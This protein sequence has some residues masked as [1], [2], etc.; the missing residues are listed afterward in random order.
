VI[1]KT[2]TSKDA[3]G[4]T[5]EYE[6]PDFGTYHHTTPEDSEEIRKQAK[7]LFSEAF[8]D[9]P[10]P[11]DDKLKILDIGCGLGFL[12]CVCAEYYPNGMV[13]AFDTFEDPSLENSSLEKAKKN[14]D[15]LG[16]SG[17]IEFQKGDI[18]QSNYSVD[19]F[20]LFVSNLVFHN[21]GERRLDAYD[22]LASW[23]RPESYVVLGELF[24]DY[25][26]D[27]KRLTSL[28][29]KVEERPNSSTMA[30][31]YKI[32]VLSGPKKTVGRTS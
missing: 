5:T 9:L 18:L 11:R 31:I 32:M 29:G 8:A 17:R 13:T 3:E 22:R 7:V 21:L 16:Y 1:L 12:S 30:G 20:D 24:F 14:A 26:T 10:F 2:N 28:F 27:Y 25:E 6:Q 19:Q 15:I 4:K 23:M